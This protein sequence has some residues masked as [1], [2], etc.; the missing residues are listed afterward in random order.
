MEDF[1]LSRKFGYLGP[2]LQ[3]FVPV[4]SDARFVVDNA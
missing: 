2:L 4:H 3:L 1:P